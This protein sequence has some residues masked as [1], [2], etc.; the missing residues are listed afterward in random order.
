MDKLRVAVI[1]AGIAQK[2]LIGFNAN[3]DLY[4]VKVLCSLDEERG[5]KAAAEAG[6]AE[7]TTDTNS[8]FERED[9]DVIDVCTPPHNHFDLVERTIRAGKHS[10]CEKPLFGSIADVDRMAEV[11]KGTGLKMMPIFQY[12]YGA[13]LQKLKHLI[14]AGL[15][16]P[17]FMTTVETH[18]WRPPAYYEVE[19]RGKWATELGGGL[20]GHAIH[21][22]DM[23]NYVHGPCAEV[24]AFGDTLLND[25]EVEDSMALAV[26]MANGSLATLSMTLGSREEISR[27]RFCFK[28]LVAE[29]ITAPYTMGNDPWKFVAGDPAHQEKVDAALAAVEPHADHYARQFELFAQ[30]IAGDTDPPVTLQ[31]ARNALELVTAAYHSDRTGQPVPMPLKADHPL[32]GSWLPKAEEVRKK[33]A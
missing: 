32:Y 28:N 1:G 14:D 24:F 5:R 3:P 17:A 30:S 2:H 11:V 16:G 13:G 25:I 22:H 9:I 7:F 15:T 27:L 20:L 12:R 4:E 8:L 33:S 6:V 26:R 21:A 29:S 23:L 10:I 19:W 18:W 31:D